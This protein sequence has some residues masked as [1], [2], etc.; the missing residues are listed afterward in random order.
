MKLRVLHL[1]ILWYSLFPLQNS[2]VPF[3]GYERLSS[4]ILLKIPVIFFLL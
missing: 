2:V 1:H 4:L 3:C